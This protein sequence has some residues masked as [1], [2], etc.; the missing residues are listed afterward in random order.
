MDSFFN[1]LHYVFK[2]SLLFVAYMGGFGVLIC[3][4]AIGAM[5]VWGVLASIWEEIKDIKNEYK[6]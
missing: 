3:A 6:D 4:V 2:Y 5:G 1:T